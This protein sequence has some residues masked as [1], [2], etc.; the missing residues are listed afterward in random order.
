[1]SYSQTITAPSSLILPIQWSVTNGSLPV[2]LN[3]TSVTGYSITISGVP[4]VDGT[5]S[6]RV[7]AVDHTAQNFS[8]QYLL[9]IVRSASLNPNTIADATIGYAY[10][11]TLTATGG[12]GPYSWS[13]TTGTLPPGIS[14]S[15]SGSISGTPT[16]TGSYTLTVSARDTYGMTQSKGISLTVRSSSQAPVITTDGL[17]VGIV[18]GSYSVYLSAS[19]GSPSY[20]WSQVSGNL[21]TNVYL[22]SDGSLR[23]T[24][25]VS[26]SFIFTAR[27]SD[28]VGR[29]SDHTYTLV[30]VSGSSDLTTR[31]ANYSRIGVQ[32][33]QLVKLADDL[34]ATTQSDSAVYYLGIDGRRHAF[35]S[36]K[37]YNTWY[38][39]FFSVNTISAAD[40]ASIPLGVNVSYQPGTKMVKFTSDPKVY[41]VA[42]GG[43]LRWIQSESV[44]N[45]LYGP[46]WNY[47]IDDI[48]DGFYADYVISPS[49]PIIYSGDFSPSATSAANNNPSDAMANNP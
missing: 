32:P 1:M 6:F 35:T 37:V 8:L 3:L 18:S 41:A 23:G 24:P 19:G 39:D 10:Q 29:T 49:N 25:I 26:G 40:L 44:A 48:P 38:A 36:V 5:S 30:V 21:P 4:V 33:H 15:S 46:S 17:P 34:N 20:S 28:A 42:D 2:G 16:L 45:A 11:Q 7:Q 47:Q 27:V 12:T 9:S 43:Q 14:M 22:G 13:I 31:L